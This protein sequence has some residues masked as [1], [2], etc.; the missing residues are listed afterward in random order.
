MLLKESS[1]TG[2]ANHDLPLQHGTHH[3]D[4]SVN[5]IVV[6]I[7]NPDA[8]LD[9]GVRVENEV[10]AIT[11]MHRALAGLPYNTV[12]KVFAW[13]VPSPGVSGWIVEEF[14]EGEK[15]SQHLP[16]LSTDEQARILDQVAKLFGKIQAFD[17]EMNGFGGLRFDANGRVVAGRSS[18]WSIGPFS[19]YAD[20]YQGIFDKQL[21]LVATTP[22]LDGWSAGGLKERL[23]HFGA[24]GGLRSVLRPFEDMR[25][26]L[27][28]GDICQ[29]PVKEFNTK[30]TSLQRQ[31][32]S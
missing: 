9:E 8:M 22:L 28:H 23:H 30:L 6:R 15:L 24:S 18:L 16:E 25:S 4:F 26:T 19:N 5:K 3:L 2:N 1:S 32:I 31:R 17:P 14:M 7:S 13:E 20:L 11:L 29:Y 12:P 10:A 27:V 21:E